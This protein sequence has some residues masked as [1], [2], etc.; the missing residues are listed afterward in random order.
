MIIPIAKV[1]EMR[2]QY[3]TLNHEAYN[4]RG[5]EGI[6][7]ELRAKA[8]S[9]LAAAFAPYPIDPADVV[10]SCITIEGDYGFIELV[11]RATW[12]PQMV[13][14]VDLHGGRRDGRKYPLQYPHSTVTIRSDV[15]SSESEKYG[16]AGFD[17]STRRFVF[18]YQERAA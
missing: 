3:A 10:L 6:E 2:Q 5:Y 13:D 18:D 9:V 1:Q 14:A 7:P 16:L 8:H 11:Y 17:T 4:P 12:D 15:G